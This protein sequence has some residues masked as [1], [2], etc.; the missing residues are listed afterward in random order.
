MSKDYSTYFRLPSTKEA[1]RRSKEKVAIIRDSFV[2][3]PVLQSIVKGKKFHL[4]T[5]GCQANERDEEVIA[6]ILETIG[7][8]RTTEVAQA[9]LI[10]L[11][12]CAIR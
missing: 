1:A 9:D 10:L 11:N 4:S 7:Y 5:F 8:E 2:V 12:T 3:N 6:G